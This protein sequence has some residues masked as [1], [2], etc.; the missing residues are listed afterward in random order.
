MFA[1][2][3][4]VNSEVVGHHVS[5]DGSRFS[6][7]E[8]ISQAVTSRFGGIAADAARGVTLRLDNGPQ[9]TSH[10]LSHQIGH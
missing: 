7:L 3:D 6:A 1:A 8:P 2:I 10:P 9:D 4:H 5:T